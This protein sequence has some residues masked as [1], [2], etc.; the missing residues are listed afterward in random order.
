MLYPVPFAAEHLAQMQLQPAQSWLSAH[1]D[2][3]SMR[4]LENEWSST[5]M[6]DGRPLAAAGVAVYWQD[7]AYVWSLISKDV[8]VSNFL[9]VHA[10]AKAFIAGLPFRRLEA[11]VDC[12][13]E[14]GHRWAEAL[15]FE[16][17]AGRMRAFQVDGRDCALYA[18]V[19]G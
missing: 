13:F 18:R 12:D 9:A 19:K 10:H 15:G 17:E 16:L 6:D 5:L 8:K 4:S 3:A 11:G 7:R 14:A 2:V 1:T